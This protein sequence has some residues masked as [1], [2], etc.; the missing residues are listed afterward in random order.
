MM[1][2]REREVREIDGCFLKIGERKRWLFH[3]ATVL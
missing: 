2:R 3:E 1:W